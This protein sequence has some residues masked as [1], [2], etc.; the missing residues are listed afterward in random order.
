MLYL[1]FP[2]I[3]IPPVVSRKRISKSY[4]ILNKK[5]KK[6][7][8]KFT[9]ALSRNDLLLKASVTEH[10]F[11]ITDY[12]EFLH[13]QKAFKKAITKPE[14]VEQFITNDGIAECDITY[15]GNR[16]NQL[17][18]YASNCEVIE[19]KIKKQAGVVI[20]DIKS[21]ELSLKT[22][23]ELIHQLEEAQNMLPYTKELQTLYSNLAGAF[24]SLSNQESI[25]NNI[26]EEYYK[27]FF[28]YSYLEKATLKELLKERENSFT[29]YTKAELKQKNNEK[30]KNFYGFINAASLN[31]AEFMIN[32]SIRLMNNNFLKFAQEKGEVS[33]ELYQIWVTL[34]NNLSSI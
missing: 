6:I 3:F 1:I 8:T 27:S 32:S 11:K 25:R 30:S 19:K 4:D 7:L 13:Y 26:F 12:N 29:E 34:I 22:L 21:M 28:K 9:E 24:I 20:N 17:T 31:E 15:Q 2:G 5:R 23:G 18:E 33:T 16:I 10:F 14:S